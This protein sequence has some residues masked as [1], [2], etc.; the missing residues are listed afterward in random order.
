MEN[1][2]FEVLFKKLY[3]SLCRYVFL[4]VNDEDI[5]QDIV[6]EQFIYL[7]EYKHKIN[8]KSYQA[9]LYKSVKN[10][11]IN[12]LKSYHFQ[13]KQKL[14]KI[15][16]KYSSIN[17]TVEEIKQKELSEI[18]HKAIEKLPPKC[19]NIFYLKKFEGLSNKEIAIKLS[20]SIKTVENQM[21]IAI[22]KI[23]TFINK[24]W[25]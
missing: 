22:K 17:N 19:H 3:P 21:T 23:S 24:H 11:A 6:Q 8:I 7:W 15:T 1:G 18:I 20:I 12:Y 4:M 5:A 13:N 10:K 9:Y 2:D 14:N 16:E 25:E